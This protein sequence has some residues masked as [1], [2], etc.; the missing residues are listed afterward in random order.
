MADQLAS[1]GTLDGLERAMRFA[2]D[3]ARLLARAAIYRNDNGDPSPAVD[4][5]LRRVAR[6]NP[7]DSTV[8]MTLGLREEFRGNSADAEGY[9]VRAAEIDHQF[10]PAWTLANY[11]YRTNRPDK[12]WAMIAR[13]LS[14]EPL[15]FNP[16]PVFELCWRLASDNQSTNQDTASRKI[17]SVI[18]KRGH[19]AVQYLEFLI[20]T[21]RPDAALD[22]WPN[23]LAAAD[24]TD[25]SDVAA[26][27]Q[28][29]DSLTGADRIPEAVNV[30]NQ[31]VERGMI[32]SGRL[33]PAKGVSIAD[34]DFQFPPMAAAFGWRT[35]EIPGVFTSGF[36][37]SLRFEI[38]GDEPQS[39]QLL[40]TL[41]PVLSGTPYH[42]RW[43]SD[44]SSLSSTGDPGFSFVIVQRH[45]LG[46][47]SEA[48]TQCPPLLAPGNQ[49][50]DFLT[51]AGNGPG[52]MGE[53]R[54]DLH[55]TRALGT[56]RVSG[57]LQL[58]NVHLELAR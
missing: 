11:Y 36:S 26:L 34:P 38:N 19:K 5:D 45:S 41:A 48:T 46:Q 54:I 13:I 17:L 20:A 4:E 22:A 31:L 16:A 12:A 2:P 32:H 18:P 24:P 21:H 33:D 49:A 37:G 14:L 29:A 25:L 1:A 55:Y 6:L 57:T 53:A 39:F 56:T 50:C 7:F 52:D 47:P 43:R 23:A 35:T 9:L 44:G 10:K 8:L 58:L 15:G 27:T 30:W 28:F 42:L 3:D 51:P 40:S